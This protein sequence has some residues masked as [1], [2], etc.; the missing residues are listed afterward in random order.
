MH[1]RGPAGG[2]ARTGAALDVDLDVSARQTEPGQDQGDRS[3]D[4]HAHGH[5][6]A[7]EEGEKADDGSEKEAKQAHADNI[8]DGSGSVARLAQDAS[9]RAVSACVSFQRRQPAQGVFARVA[10]HLLRRAEARA[11]RR[12]GRLAEER[13]AQIRQQLHAG[14]ASG[15]PVVFLQTYMKT[16]TSPRLEAIM[17][18]PSAPAKAYS[19]LRFSTPEQEQGDS[20]RR[21][22]ALAREYAARK[23]LV[24]DEELT[25]ADCG[26][27]AFRGANLRRDNALGAFLEAVEVGTV[28]RGSYLLVENLDRL[29]RQTARKALRTLED[30]ID[31]G[32]TVVTLN[33]EHEYTAESLDDGVSFD[34]MIALLSMMRAHQESVI[35][36]ER[37]RKE[38]LERIERA[39]RDKVRTKH[40]HP[41]W[42]RW[43]GTLKAYAL[44]PERAE[45]VRRI[46]KLALSG[47]GKDSIAAKLNSER[48]PVFGWGV[49][50]Y[51][52]AILKLLTNRAAIG[53]L[54]PNERRYSEDGRR[55][56]IPLGTIKNYYPAA[57]SARDFERVALLSK[58][59]NNPRRGRHA[60]SPVSN[61]LG[62]LARC[63]E[64]GGAMT[65][66]NKGKG[67]VAYLVC[68]DA[69]SGN[70]CIYH[71]VKYRT[72]EEAVFSQAEDIVDDAPPASERERQCADRLSQLERD[73]DATT[74]AIE[75]LTRV[76]ESGTARQR[77]PAAL[78]E[79]ILE[80][81]T[82]AARLSEALKA[83]REELGGLGS[84]VIAHRLKELRTALRD[85]TDLPRANAALRLLV[86]AVTV[87]YQRG[88]LNFQWRHGG[89]SKLT[90]AWPAED[91]PR[92]GR[93]P[94]QRAK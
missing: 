35:K 5:D 83:T 53:E 11:H 71:T 67:N 2:R 73:Y 41:S 79:R 75:H 10:A 31:R 59:A 57:V 19:Y 8:P 32:I 22:I 29:S 16:L 80:L 26:V 93:K 13:A 87:D 17:A 1:A 55:E 37:V 42:L 39:R 72:V 85:R 78:R 86:E 21:Q 34:L 40:S 81:E 45:I 60:A 18:R 49:R 76:A 69:K 90:Y 89:T 68:V 48:I 24:L 3:A 30:I 56:L 65:R 64:C 50:W 47:T 54:N 62:G 43:D 77:T 88:A 91:T 12:P 44:I 38:Y 70:G 33:P 15:L 27:S 14:D 4:E 74:E 92:R 63:P 9:C 23:G 51:G 52:S 84:A 66:V 7:H 58:A 46:F 82:E 6:A 36:R 25:L 28:P 94:A 61:I 20:K